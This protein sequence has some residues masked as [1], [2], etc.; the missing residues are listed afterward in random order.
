MAETIEKVMTTDPVTIPAAAPV[1][2]AAQAMRRSHIG[3][4]IVIDDSDQIA[5][6]VTDRDIA[7]RV[8]AE[9]RDPSATKIEDI[10]S[11]DIEVLAPDDSVADAVK[12]MSEKAIRRI[13]VVADGRPV[14]I[15]SLGDLARSRDPKSALAAISAAPPDA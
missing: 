4:V 13:P 7:I 15:V 6:I 12:L 14:G 5:G 10:Y 3:D 8:V 2:D 11:K 9:G 1:L